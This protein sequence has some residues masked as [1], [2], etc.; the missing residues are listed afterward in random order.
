MIEDKS[1]RS[2]PLDSP[3]KDRPPGP[4]DRETES[5]L[6]YGRWYGGALQ[7]CGCVGVPE[8]QHIP[9]CSKGLCTSTRAVPEATADD[10]ESV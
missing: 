1:E 3:M 2:V 9:G 7:D 8:G 6:I 5:G 10:T 4:K